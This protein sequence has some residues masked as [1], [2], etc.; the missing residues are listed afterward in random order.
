VG[1]IAE[2]AQ[3]IPGAGPED[4]PWLLVVLRHDDGGEQGLDFSQVLR[5][6][7]RLGKAPEAEGRDGQRLG[8]GYETF[9]V[10][11]RKA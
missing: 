10:F 8:V 3:P 6:G 1:V 7:T 2:S 5:V 4:V 11:L 9:Y